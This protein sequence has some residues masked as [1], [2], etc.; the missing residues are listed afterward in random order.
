MFQSGHCYYLP[1]ISRRFCTD[2]FNYSTIQV[3]DNAG[4]NIMTFHIHRKK[5]DD[6]IF[7]HEVVIEAASKTKGWQKK[8]LVV[9]GMEWLEGKFDKNKVVKISLISLLICIPVHLTKIHRLRPTF[10]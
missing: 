8:Q 5:E 7:I 4:K 2:L 9:D 10:M 3:F 1:S 6:E